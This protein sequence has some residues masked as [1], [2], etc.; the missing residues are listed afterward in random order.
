MLHY[1]HNSLIYNSQELETTQM[2]LNKGM[3]TENIVY[4]HNGVLVNY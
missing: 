4:L 3:Y 1:V 2:P